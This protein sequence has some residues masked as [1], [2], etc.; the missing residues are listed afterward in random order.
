LKSG[1]D[2]EGWVLATEILLCKHSKISSANG[3]PRV[4]GVPIGIAPYRGQRL[5]HHRRLNPADFAGS[6]AA[7]QLDPV[8]CAASVASN[9]LELV[10]CAG[11]IASNQLD[12]VVRAGSV[13]S[14]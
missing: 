10:D 9:Q 4:R 12:P 6:V 7:N 2:A 14:N 11:S 5:D 13:A 3:A 8:V 1:R